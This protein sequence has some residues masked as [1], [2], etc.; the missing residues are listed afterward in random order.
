VAVAVVVDVDDDD[1][2]FHSCT[3]TRLSV[4]SSMGAVHAHG[5][6]E[7]SLIT[8]DRDDSVTMVRSLVFVSL[9]Y[10]SVCL[11]TSRND[12]SLMTIQPIIR[13]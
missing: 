5:R 1:V 13:H 11:S 4:D 12:I 2:V 7:F 8:D 3:Y 10:L 9:F 6:T